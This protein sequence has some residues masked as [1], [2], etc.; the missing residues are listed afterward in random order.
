VSD[1][2][3]ER[4][5]EMLRMDGA[6]IEFRVERARIEPGA[7]FSEE[8]MSTLNADIGVWIGTRVMRRWEATGEPPSVLIVRLEV[9]AQ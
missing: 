4:Y 8:A 7:S 9:E 2:G 1:R 3:E 5:R 6:T